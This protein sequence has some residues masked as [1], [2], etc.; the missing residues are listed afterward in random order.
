MLTVAS[1]AV[2]AVG[3]GCR[4]ELDDR[5]WLVRSL[6]IV[7]VKLEP[8]EVTPGTETT[9]NVIAIGPD[10]VPDVSMTA[11]ALCHSSKSLGEDRVVSP[12]CLAPSTTDAIGSPVHLTVPTDACQSFGPN[13]P[14]P[15]AGEPPTRPHDPDASGGYY[16]P[17]TASLGASVAATLERVR[18]GLAD[19]SLDVA[20][21]FQ[22]TYRPNENPMITSLTLDG[23]GIPPRS[24][25]SGATVSL[26]VAW[27]AMSME[28]FPVFDRSTRG[29]VT[30]DEVLTVSWYVTGGTLER[31]ASEVRDR[32]ILSTSTSWVAPS[33]PAQVELLVMLRDS[34]GGSDARH[35]T[36]LVE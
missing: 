28:S 29:L 18:C 14:Q 9:A 6:Q 34:R 30:T 22:D 20:R 11:W 5:P 1:L 4:P 19:A 33:S 31:A 16:Q 7:G 24:I 32:A 12:D 17:V 26:D 2:L 25:P 35:L 27:S 13:V 3:V 10:A 36:V 23:V 21:A 15:A 8:P